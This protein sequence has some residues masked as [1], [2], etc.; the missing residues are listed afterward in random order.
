MAQMMKGQSIETAAEI[1]RGFEV[2]LLAATNR[3]ET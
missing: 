3:G 2:Q 1:T